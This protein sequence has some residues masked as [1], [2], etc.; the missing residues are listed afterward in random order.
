MIGAVVSDAMFAR[1]T[2]TFV[3]ALLLALGPGC[4]SA[5]EVDPVDRFVEVFPDQTTFTLEIP[6]EVDV[7]MVSG[8]LEVVEA[9]LIGQP[10]SLRELT[11][12]VRRYL[13]ELIDR[14]TG[15]IDHLTSGSPIVREGD[16]A[17]WHTRNP[18]NNR[19]RLLVMHKVDAHFEFTL[20]T[21]MLSSAAGV[22]PPWQFVALG[23]LTPGEVDL[24]RG[25]M[26]IDLEHDNFTPSRGKMSL[27]WSFIGDHEQIEVQVF[28]GT[29]NEDE[30]G[31]LTRSYRYE[32][33]PDGGMLAFDA[34]MINVHQSPER[35][36]EERVRV[37]TRWSGINHATTGPKR[38]VRADYSA[39]GP[40]VRAD[41]FRV[42]IGSE[43]WQTPAGLV[44]YESRQGLPLSGP[45]LMTQFERGD[46]TS[47]PFDT[48]EPPVVAPPG[49]PPT[50][51][52][53]PEELDMFE[54]GQG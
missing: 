39:I 5:G 14:L 52:P 38:S 13:L 47:C 46:A 10:S 43:C 32:N 28:D 17:V 11:T 50:E 41:G 48:Q 34:G 2:I 4:D 44:T 12:G 9:P 45:P 42:V 25:A 22:R 35:P 18:N 40:E 33:G 51:P 29:P 16:R 23:R 15:S 21:R 19:E 3:G 31:R 30:V 36:G 54:R 27:L 37:F 6:G 20:W 53:P 8:A 49:T 7:E 26:W 24:G 1:S